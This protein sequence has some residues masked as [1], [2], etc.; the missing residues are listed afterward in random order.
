MTPRHVIAPPANPPL[1]LRLLAVVRSRLR[2]DPGLRLA[3]QVTLAMRVL[4]GAVALISLAVHGSGTTIE[5]HPDAGTPSG[6]A[7]TPLVGPWER[8]DGLWYLHIAQDGY[9]Q[10]G[11]EA[12]FSPLFPALVRL[13]A[14]ITGG[15]VSLAA[16]LLT[17][18]AAAAAL[19]ATWHL[20]ADVLGPRVARCTVLLLALYPAAF[21]L[22]A[23]YPESLFIALSASAL[24]AARRRHWGWAGVAASFAVLCRP[25]GAALVAALALEALL[26]WR[27][28][29]R[30]HRGRWWTG[31]RAMGAAPVVAIAAPV[32][33]LG[34]WFLYCRVALGL[35]FGELT[36]LANWGH[37]WVPF[38]QVIADSAQSIADGNHPEEVGNLLVAAIV[39]ALLP[40]MARRL[41]PSWTVYTAVGL[42]LSLNNEP[43]FEP[44]MSLMRYVLVLVPAFALLA[45]VHLR[46]ALLVP[47]A[48]IAVGAQVVL[49]DRFV[50]HLF[51]A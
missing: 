1:P 42:A 29:R 26:A 18:V 2:G 6:S 46:R 21:F 10:S 3:L 38:W 36:A 16:W 40:V 15:N 51:V 14:V 11:P 50:H 43:S 17:T 13:L 9:P 45:T 8:W 39:V 47:L 44:L 48:V 34:G 25:Q 24:L 32:L 37:H 27:A 28:A 20:V 22:I 23:P 12:A 30:D 49:V 31:L 7:L 19:W 4:L 35:Q 5:E 33:L 41:P